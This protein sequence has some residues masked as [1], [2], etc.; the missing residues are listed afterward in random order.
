MI[1]YGAPD[2]AAFS[3]L[4]TVE[5]PMED[6]ITNQTSQA[7]RIMLLIVTYMSVRLP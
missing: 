7:C 4:E 2:T 5:N 6:T 1:W 3:P